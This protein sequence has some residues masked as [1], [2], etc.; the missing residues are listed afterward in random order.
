MTL[1]PV[2][3][4]FSNAARASGTSSNATSR[5]IT[6][7]ILP[8]AGELQDVRPHGDAIGGGQEVHPEQ[9]RTSGRIDEGET[10][11]RQTSKLP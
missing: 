7:R 6:G 10:A 9:P 8:V 1:R 5:P 11:R 4:R 2:V 3:C